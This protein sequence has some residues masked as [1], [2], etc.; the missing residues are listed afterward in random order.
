MPTQRG[1]HGRREDE[2]VVLPL[3]TNLHTLFELLLPPPSELC[4]RV[5]VDRYVAN[6]VLGLGRREL[7]TTLSALH[8]CPRQGRANPNELGV[9]IDPAP[10]WHLCRVGFP[11]QRAR[12]S[13]TKARVEQQMPQRR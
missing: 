5:V 2:T 3:G 12:F 4:D 1:P 11:L 6:R 13:W 8:A 9:E 7:P 10:P